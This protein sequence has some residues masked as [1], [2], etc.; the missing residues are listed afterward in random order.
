ME[1][2]VPNSKQDKSY[3][4]GMN[5][6]NFLPVI[7]IPIVNILQRLVQNVEKDSSL[8]KVGIMFVPLEYAHM[9]RNHVLDVEM[10]IWLNDLLERS[11][12]DAVIILIVDTQNH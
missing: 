7:I 12:L 10:V 3:Q 11:F 5:E 1:E 9:K 4:G 2:T 6:D 8:N